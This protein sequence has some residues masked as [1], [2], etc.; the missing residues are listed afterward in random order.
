MVLLYPPTFTSATSGP[1]DE[2]TFVLD[3]FLS[4]SRHLAVQTKDFLEGSLPTREF[5]QLRRRFPPGTPEYQ[6]RIDEL[7]KTP[8]FK[9]T[10]LPQ[11]STR[12]K[13]GFF[14]EQNH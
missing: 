14:L 2:D 3:D 10:L 7:I 9:A 8:D 13:T 4:S 11:L 5:D 1:F 6:A 12:G